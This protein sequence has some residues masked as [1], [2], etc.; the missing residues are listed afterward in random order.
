MTEPSPLPETQEAAALALER[1][2]EAIAEA[3]AAYHGADA[4]VMDDAAYDALRRQARAIEARFP[5]LIRADSPIARVGAPPEGR[6]AKHRHRTP[7]LSLDNAFDAA[8]FDEFIARICRFLGL[9]D[10][11]HTRLRMVAEPK[12]DGLSLSLTYEAGRLVTAATRGDG[13]TG[14]DVTA[15]IRVIDAIPKQLAGEAPALIEIRGEIFLSKADFLELNRRREAAGEPL[16]ANPRNAAAGSLRQLDAAIT[17]SRPLSFF[18]Y[19]QGESSEPVAATHH[20]YLARL[21]SWGFEVN[22]LNTLIET[23]AQAADFHARLTLERADLAYDI[24]GVVYKIDDLALQTRLGFVGRA[25]RWAIAWKFAAEQAVTR[26]EDIRIQVGRTGA[27]TPVAWL[28]AINVGG[29]IVTRATLHNADEIARKDIRVG[30]R[31][32]VQ[33]AGDVIPQILGFVEEPDRIR[34]QPYVF[35][36]HCPACGSRAERPPGEV[37]VRCTGGLICP[38]Q[39]VERLIHLASRTAFDIDGLGEKTV[40]EFFDAGLLRTPADIFRLHRHEA[41]ILARK[42]WKP[43]SVRKLLAGIEQRR[44]IALDRFIYGLGIRRIGETNARLLARH[45]GSY[46]DWRA[47]MLEATTVGSD[48]RLALGSINGIGG[49]IAD[50][51]AVFFCE[52]H[53]RAAVDD[54]ATE[55]TIAPLAAET[56]SGALSGRTLVF[57]GTLVT[58]TRPEAKAIAL[59]LGAKVTE[60]VSKRTDLVIL[61]AEA[62]SKA[63][64]AAE[65]G[66]ETTDEAGWRILAGLGAQDDPAGQD[67]QG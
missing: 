55:L 32:R 39:A 13:Q 3:D 66:I 30:D 38:A 10:D 60:T 37:V 42:G 26:L 11:A 5:A 23:P 59:R 41:E 18:A 45:Y 36:D 15:N 52:T 54:L 67:A 43:T 4:P 27:L 17:A 63:K 31:V 1:L 57:T 48:A 12:I 61:G 44:N 28:E 20:D 6:F 19:A 16:F 14:E 47:Q 22:A 62:G 33:R 65:L 35:P 56:S 29:V 40:V 9:K 8:D 64:R 51:L 46:D 2:A 53:N 21:R 34:E 50:E 25:P 7:M 24:D 49:V 58:M